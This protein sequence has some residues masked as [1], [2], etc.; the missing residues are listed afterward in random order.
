MQ[1]YA[2]YALLENFCMDYMLLYTAKIAVKNPAGYGRLA[3]SSVLGACFAVLFPLIKLS[4]VLGTAVKIAFGFVM[5]AVAGK[6]A[7]FKGYLLFCGA[8]TAATFVLGGALVAL[9]SLANISYMAGEGY[10]ISSV[11]VGIPLFCLFLLA[12]AVKA[13]LKRFGKVSRR[14]VQCRIYCG[15]KAAV[16]KGFFD[17]GN[18]VY[19]HGAPV[20]VVPVYIACKLVD[21]S[22]IKSFVEIHTV[23]GNSKISVFTADKIEIDDGEKVTERRGVLLGVSP[24]HIAAIVLNPDLAEVS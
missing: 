19:H 10:L 18:K 9:F 4:G 22:G 5:C 7:K 14:Q 12:A 2:E 1:I 13:L 23:A 24:K 11:P 6:F 20:S 3:V 15:E 21:I 16:C 8:F 17:S